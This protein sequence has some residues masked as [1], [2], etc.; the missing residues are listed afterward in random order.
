M[1]DA[2][3]KLEGTYKDLLDIYFAFLFIRS[4]WLW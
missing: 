4:D 2:L 1:E 3:K